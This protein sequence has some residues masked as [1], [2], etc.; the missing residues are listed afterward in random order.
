MSQYGPEPEYFKGPYAGQWKKH[1][2][3]VWA[4]HKE[5]VRRFPVLERS[6]RVGLGAESSELI[7]IHR[8]RRANPIWTC[9]ITT[10]LYAI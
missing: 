10:I 2:A 3:N 7:Q 8:T 1:A 4:L 9:T 6:I 5:L